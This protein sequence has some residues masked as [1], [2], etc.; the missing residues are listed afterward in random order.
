MKN[1]CIPS[2]ANALIIIEFKIMLEDGSAN[3]VILKKFIIVTQFLQLKFTTIPTNKKGLHPPLKN[4][5]LDLVLDIDAKQ[6][7]NHKLVARNP[8]QRFSSG[9]LISMWKLE[10]SRIEVN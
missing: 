10:I 7:Q 4:S 3:V 2:H 8:F 9:I 1:A 6:L 5:F